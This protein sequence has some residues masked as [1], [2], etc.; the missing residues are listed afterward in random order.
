MK[1]FRLV[2]AALSLACLLS[3]CGNSDR[4]TAL[5]QVVEQQNKT[6]LD[7]QK[8]L[9]DQQQKMID[10]ELRLSAI[11]EQVAMDEELLKKLQ[12]SAPPADTAAPSNVD[13]HKVA[14]VRYLAGFSARLSANIGYDAYADALSDLNSNLVT[15]MLDIKEQSFIDE[16]NRILS[17]YNYAGEFWQHFAADGSDS[18]RL[19]EIERYKYANV[20]VNFAVNYT[21]R[22]SDVK[23]FW[24]AASDELQKLVDYNREALG[25]EDNTVRLFAR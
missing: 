22:P 6:I 2:P 11:T 17:M 21:A 16:V 19:S 18:L 14:V 23:K 12:S 9:L 13:Q 4:Y 8:T 25:R 10:Q 5:S 3:A 15:G 20:G 1:T 7:Q 24:L